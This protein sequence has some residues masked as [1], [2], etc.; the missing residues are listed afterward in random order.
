MRLR[1]NDTP[2]TDCPTH[3]LG[4]RVNPVAEKLSPIILSVADAYEESP[5]LSLSL[6]RAEEPTSEAISGGSSSSRKSDGGVAEWSLVS[7]GGQGVVAHWSILGLTSEIL[8][9]GEEINE[10]PPAGLIVFH[11]I[12]EY[13]VRS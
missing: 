5:V 2:R 1:A 4:S 10:Y 9:E 3:P 7:G 11:K 6:R 13:V 12:G 8:R